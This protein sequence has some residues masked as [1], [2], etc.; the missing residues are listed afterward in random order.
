MTRILRKK[1]QNKPSPSTDSLGF[2]RSEPP[3]DDIFGDKL[4]TVNI[5]SSSAAAAVAAVVTK[6]NKV[7]LTDDLFDEDIFQ[8]KPKS[9]TKTPKNEDI[10]SIFDDPLSNNKQ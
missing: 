10:Q 5:V 7:P 4:T 9:K 8:V 2:G 1:N 3:D 6:S